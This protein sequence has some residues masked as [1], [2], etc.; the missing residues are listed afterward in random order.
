MER[1]QQAANTPEGMIDWIENQDRINKEMI[2][3]WKAAQKG[4]EEY[5]PGYTPEH[6]QPI[7]EQP[8][9]MPMDKFKEVVGESILDIF[10]GALPVPGILQQ[11]LEKPHLVPNAQ[12]FNDLFESL[13]GTLEG[14][15]TNLNLNLQSTTQ[16]VVDGRTLATVIKPYLY[17]D[18]LRFE[19]AAGSVSKNLVI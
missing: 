19:S 17:E 6:I 5:L 18:M 8:R 7:G 13:K 14:I 3:S 11:F 12:N 1:Q 16:L 15:S 4:Y 10:L 2:D 9:T